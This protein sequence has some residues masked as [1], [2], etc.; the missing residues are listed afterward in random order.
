VGVG[1]DGVSRL[2]RGGVEIGRS[3]FGGGILVIIELAN[4]CF[5][6]AV[7]VSCSGRN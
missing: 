6:G 2:E 1:V 4:K 3:V 5:D 7:G